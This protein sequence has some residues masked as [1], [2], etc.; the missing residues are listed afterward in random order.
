MKKQL[1]AL[2]VALGIGLAVGVPVASADQPNLLFIGTA[3]TGTGGTAKTYPA[4]LLVAFDLAPVGFLPPCFQEGTGLVD[5]GV[6]KVTIL[7]L[8]Y[9][10]ALTIGS[11]TTTIDR[12]GGSLYVKGGIVFL[13]LF[14]HTVDGGRVSMNATATL[15]PGGGASY[16]RGVGTAT[17]S[18]G[19]YRLSFNSLG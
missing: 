14:M 7:N 10:S 6:C 1:A 16:V 12:G 18:S 11:Q 9:T 13:T 3:T 19:T 15:L 4:S 17:L 8:F 2:L 5:G